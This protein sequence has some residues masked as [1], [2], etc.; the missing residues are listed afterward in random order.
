MPQHEQETGVLQS[1]STEINVFRIYTAKN[2]R[3]L[4]S[5]ASKQCFILYKTF[6]VKRVL[7]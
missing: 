3:K 1:K 4:N 2:E 6:M 5:L 7:N